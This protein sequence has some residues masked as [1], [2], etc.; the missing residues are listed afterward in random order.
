MLQTEVDEWCDKPAVDRRS[1]C[2]LGSPTTAQLFG[3]QI[4]RVDK[5]FRPSRLAGRLEFR[6]TPDEVPAKS[7]ARTSFLEAY[8][9]FLTT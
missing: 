7:T 4:G 9:N 1:Y 6:T 5:K 8:V 3:V 2:E